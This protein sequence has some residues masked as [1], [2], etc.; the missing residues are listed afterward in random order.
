MFFYRVEREDDLERISRTGY[1]A[2][3][4]IAHSTSFG[5]NRATPK[6][7]FFGTD[8]EVYALNEARLQERFLLRFNK[9]LLD[10]YEILTDQEF[11]Y[12]N[13]SYYIEFENNC[14][15]NMIIRP[16]NI[17]ILINGQ[18]TTL[19]SIIKNV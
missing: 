19:L 17:E 11:F 12:G 10:Q 5:G 3:G 7:Y 15:N 13:H 8:S 18:W 2:R 4:C 14:V 6:I 16:E 9:H 1:I